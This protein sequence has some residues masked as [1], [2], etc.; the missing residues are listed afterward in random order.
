MAALTKFR[1]RRAF[2]LLEL[3]VVL[4]IIGVLVGLTLA[5]VQ[6]V[7]ESAARLKCQNNVKQLA[8]ALH[9]YHD[10]N[11]AF[12]P[13]HRSL[14][15]P[16]RMPFSGWP[17]SILPFIEQQSL[18]EKGRTAYRFVPLPFINPPHT[19]LSTVVQTFVCPSDPRIVTAQI[20]Q[21]THTL[22]AFTSYLGVSGVGTL[23]GSATDGVLYQNSRVALLDVTDGTTNTLFLGER[24]PSA[25]FQFGW[26]YAGVGQRFTGSADM[27]LSAREPNLQPIVS[28][29]KCG[30]GQY[31]FMPASSFD[32]PCGMFHFWSPHSGGANFAFCDGSVR[33]LAYS[34]DSIMPAL[35]TRAGG[36]AVRVPE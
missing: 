34:A 15:N 7:R 19:G 4:G 25:D 30:P 1:L 23:K 27:I 24:P 14:K 3:L 13:G 5:A 26:W 21:R 33:F 22:A 9:Q 18:Y 2:T 12:P 8:L 11:G 16:D 36:E 35:A 32:D 29:S 6:R 17:L 10:A 28:G 20:S 31:P